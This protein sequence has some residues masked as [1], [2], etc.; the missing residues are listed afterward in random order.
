MI[1]F[2]IPLRTKFR[3]I[4]SRQG[5][6][7]E[8]EAGWAEFSP[9]WN[10]PVS[11]AEP[12]LRAAEEAAAGEWPVRL[13]DQIP[14]NVTV[15]V[16]SPKAAYKWVQESGCSTAK[17][18]V[19]DPGV[20][21]EQDAARL[22]AVRDAIGP[23]GKIRIDANAVWSVAEASAA[24]SVLDAAAG[25]LEYAEQPCAEV[26]ELAELRRRTPVPIAADESI[27]LAEDPYRVREL[28]AADV[29]VLKV[30][31]LGGVTACLTIAADIELP[32][33][34]SSALETGI[35]L[36]AGLAL[37]AALPTL[38]YACGLATANILATDLV[39]GGSMAPQ[40]GY[41]SARP[42]ELNVAELEQ[43]RAAPD[44]V[45]RWQRRLADIYAYR[46]SP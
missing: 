28:D 41:L 27:R 33:V 5:V 3:G 1:V 4:T 7:L 10:Y 29:V 18:K 38:N 12:W 36:S 35:G 32:V 37:A 25:G 40:N 2:D 15:P 23:L 16:I 9:F 14:V 20:S 44:V 39:G 43:Y 30:Q 42:R 24:L 31:P 34:V 6:L 8:G 11:V 19:A 26:T 13:R 46:E 22:A 17:V 45:D 21:L